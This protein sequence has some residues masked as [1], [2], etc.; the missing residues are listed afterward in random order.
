M[1]KY[2]FIIAKLLN[3]KKYYSSNISRF[4]MHLKDKTKVSKYIKKLKKLWDKKDI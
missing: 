3:K 1:N 4:Y 2:K